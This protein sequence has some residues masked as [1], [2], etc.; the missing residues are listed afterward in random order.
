MCRPYVMCWRGRT[1]DGGGTNYILITQFDM[2]SSMM[3]CWEASSR[4]HCLVRAKNIFDSRKK[5]LI[6]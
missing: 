6:K 1:D 3:L 5:F 2:C 4:M